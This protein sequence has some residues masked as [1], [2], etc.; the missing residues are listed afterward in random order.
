MRPL[1]KICT[2]A[3]RGIYTAPHNRKTVRRELRP[4]SARSSTSGARGSTSMTRLT[5]ARI[6]GVTFLAYIAAGI[7]DMRL[8]ARATTGIDV[9][10][11]RA[12]S[13]RK[14]RIASDRSAIAPVSAPQFGRRRADIQTDEDSARKASNRPG[15][16]GRCLS[17]LPR[18]FLADLPAPPGRHL[19]AWV[20]HKF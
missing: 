9:A 18:V 15:S 2:R 8:N 16:P 17:F 14:I 5:N 11:R 3:G 7:T 20:Q 10:D 6:A 13:C 19:G 1:H 12:N 4:L